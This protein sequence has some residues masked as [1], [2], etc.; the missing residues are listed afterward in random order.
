MDRVRLPLGDMRAQAILYF[1]SLADAGGRER[2]T[3][4][5][6][7]LDLEADRVDDAV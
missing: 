6:E 2:I 5:A 3:Q 4:A 1:A 7:L